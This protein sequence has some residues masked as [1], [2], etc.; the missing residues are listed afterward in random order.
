MDNQRVERPSDW[1]LN[2]LTSGAADATEQ[3][4]CR[5]YIH[6]LESD[7]VKLQSERDAAWETLKVARAMMEG[8]A[9]VRLPQDGC[10]C[11]I[12]DAARSI[13]TA[14]ANISKE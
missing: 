11:A 14:L 4:D 3:Q 8:F 10:T 9:K 13:D 1:A 7:I 2:M 6:Q 5:H 12:C